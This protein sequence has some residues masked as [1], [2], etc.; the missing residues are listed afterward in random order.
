MVGAASLTTFS[1]AGQVDLAQ[2]PG[3]DLGVDAHPVGLLAVHRE[4]L[5]RGADAGA[6][7]ALHVGGGE[8]AG[9]AGVFGEVLEGAA[10]EW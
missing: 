7:H 2:R 5:E 9:E 8:F 10:A 4:V 1:K 6:L 3:V